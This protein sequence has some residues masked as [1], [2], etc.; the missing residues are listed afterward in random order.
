MNVSELP[1][2]TGFHRPGVFDFR[3]E[4]FITIDKGIRIL[5]EMRREAKAHVVPTAV[6]MA[7]GIHDARHVLCKYILIAEEL[8]QKVRIEVK[9]R[10]LA[11]ILTYAEP[12]R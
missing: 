9:R 7:R 3:T 10:L 8:V 12:L 5:V 1:V 6:I 2:D 4:G 11:N